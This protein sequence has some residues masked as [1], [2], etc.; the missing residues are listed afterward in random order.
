[1]TDRPD[2]FDDFKYYEL[3]AGKEI[4]VWN[5]QQLWYALE[6][7]YLP[8]PVKDSAA[9]KVLE[10]A[11]QILRQIIKEGMTVEEK[12]FAIY[13]WYGDHVT[14][15]YGYEDYLY[16]DDRENFPDRLVATLNSFHAEGALFDNLAVCCSFAKSC[17][18]LLRLE[19]IEA[20]RVILHSYSDNAI[21][22]HGAGGYGSHAIIALRASDGKFYYCDP[23]QSSTGPDNVYEKFH[24]LLVTA[25]EQT[26]YEHS[27]D[28]IW[29]HL[30]Y[31]AE[32]PMELFWSH[33]TYGGQSVFV[34][35]R[36]ELLSLLET[37]FANATKN[38]QLNIFQS[39]TAEFSV[40]VILDSYGN[41]TYHK[42]C[43][44]G[45]NEYMIH[46]EK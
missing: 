22:N 29:D 4:T 42:F 44:E 43:Y 15:D 25:K 19:G 14:Y 46:L 33:L 16:P 30:D 37:Y 38:S 32:L 17:L 31:G 3:A 6:H 1:M 20:Y 34:E 18:I 35:T 12:V 7:G 9:E 13:S 23:E 2:D 39:P 8:V 21:D 27:V 40:D 24:Q 5:S 36:E 45:L 26:P 41:L 10:R 28:R 11:K